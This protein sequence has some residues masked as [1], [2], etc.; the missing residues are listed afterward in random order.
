MGSGVIV[1]ETKMR[2]SGGGK[3]KKKRKKGKVPLDAPTVGYMQ[4]RNNIH[5]NLIGNLDCYFIFSTLCWAQFFSP[6]FK[7]HSLKNMEM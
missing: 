2:P 6:F 7:A 5:M 3:V 4:K 1:S